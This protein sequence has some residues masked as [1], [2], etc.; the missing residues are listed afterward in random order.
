MNHFSWNDRHNVSRIGARLHGL[1]P[2][3][4]GGVDSSSV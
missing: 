3:C 4:G 2:V 1:M